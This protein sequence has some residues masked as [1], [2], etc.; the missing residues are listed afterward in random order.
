[1]K[2]NHFSLVSAK[3]GVNVATTKKDCLY[4]PMGHKEGFGPSSNLRSYLGLAAQVQ[5]LCSVGSLQIF[6][7]EPVKLNV[8]YIYLQFG[9]YG[10]NQGIVVLSYYS[11]SSKRYTGLF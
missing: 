6:T 7:A 2:T 3:K 9:I 5:G 8:V 10:S 11:M 4:T 1:M